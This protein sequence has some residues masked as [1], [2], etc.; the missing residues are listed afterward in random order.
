MDVPNRGWSGPLTKLENGLL[1]VALILALWIALLAN[2]ALANEGSFARED[3][4]L[5]GS[6]G[7]AAGAQ[8]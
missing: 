8:G 3:A 6:H 7:A 1:V 2:K 5:L 4:E